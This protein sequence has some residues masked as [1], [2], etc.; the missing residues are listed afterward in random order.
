M[1]TRFMEDPTGITRVVHYEVDEEEA[2]ARRARTP[3]A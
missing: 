1:T 2:Q 3:S